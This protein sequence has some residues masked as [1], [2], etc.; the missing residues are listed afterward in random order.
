MIVFS[1][2]LYTAEAVILSERSEPKDLRT[3]ITAVRN[4]NAKILRL[5]AVR[6]A[7][8]DGILRVPD[9]AGKPQTV[10][11]VSNNMPLYPIAPP[12]ATEIHAESPGPTTLPCVKNVQSG[13]ECEKEENIF[14]ILAFCGCHLVCLILK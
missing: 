3:R 8:D 14:R 10:S 6:S 12:F 13:K 9:C 2:K 1:G 4:E 11:T 7:Q 5:C